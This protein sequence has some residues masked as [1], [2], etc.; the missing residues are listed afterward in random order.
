MAVF[1]N[2]VLG[3]K[4][5]LV[6]VPGADGLISGAI[7]SGNFAAF[8]CAFRVVLP[9]LFDL[10]LDGSVHHYRCALMFGRMAWNRPGAAGFVFVGSAGSVGLRRLQHS[11]GAR[12]L[13]LD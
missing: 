7:R 5:S 13:C 10:R 11:A 8:S 3:E 1:A 4:L 6:D 9:S 2:P 12:C